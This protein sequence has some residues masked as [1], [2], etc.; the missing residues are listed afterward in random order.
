MVTLGYKPMVYFGSQENEVKCSFFLGLDCGYGS[1]IS[2]RI[3]TRGTFLKMIEW[4]PLDSY[5]FVLSLR[6]GLL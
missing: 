3:V 6:Q 5:C 4:S 1:Q 2:L